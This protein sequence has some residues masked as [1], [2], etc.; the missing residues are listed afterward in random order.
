M[1]IGEAKREGR[2]TDVCRTQNPE[3][4]GG[5]NVNLETHFSKYPT[6]EELMLP[7]YPTY[8][9]YPTYRHVAL[10]APFL[11][12]G[13]GPLQAMVRRQTPLLCVIT[14]VPVVDRLKTGNRVVVFTLS[15]ISLG[16]GV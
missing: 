7:T 8:P 5:R 6:L 12:L 9:I 2:H 11:L 3:E 14:R 13:G 1:A 16:K 10:L 4:G 15:C